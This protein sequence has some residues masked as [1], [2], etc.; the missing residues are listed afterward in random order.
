MG[1]SDLQF[2][3]HI[4]QLLA[5][6]ERALQESPDNQVL[7]AMIQMYKETLQS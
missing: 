5:E 4:R 2:K 7:K 6:L 1:M 3:T